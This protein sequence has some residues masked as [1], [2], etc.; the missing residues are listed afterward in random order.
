KKQYYWALSTSSDSDFDLHLKRPLGNC[1]IN[2]CSV[3]GIKSFRANVDL[4]PVFNHFKCVAYVC[5]YFTKDETKCLQAI[6]LHQVGLGCKKIDLLADDTVETVLNKVNNVML[7][8][9]AGIQ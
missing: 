5:S 6:M 4:Q 9:Y 3:A 1:F 2:N 7:K 8:M